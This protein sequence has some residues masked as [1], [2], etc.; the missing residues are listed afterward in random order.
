MKDRDN[1]QRAPRPGV[2]SAMAC[3]QQ[4]LVASGIMSSDSENGEEHEAR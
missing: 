1:T 2:L 4:L 3:S